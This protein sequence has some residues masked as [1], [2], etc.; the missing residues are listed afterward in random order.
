MIAIGYQAAPDVLDDDTRE[1]ELKPRSRKPLETHV[2]E[3]GWGEAVR[4]QS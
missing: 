3:G 4:L 2:F 1:K